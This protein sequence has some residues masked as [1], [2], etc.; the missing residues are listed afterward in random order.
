MKNDFQLF[1]C[2]HVTALLFMSSRAISGHFLA[3]LLSFFVKNPRNRKSFD[4][5]D[6][7]GHFEYFYGFL[8]QHSVRGRRGG[9]G[10]T[11]HF[12]PIFKST[13]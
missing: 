11:F 6:F 2:F 5:Y 1:Y 9:G 7:F 12:W 10:G 3:H 8:V 13:P 4:D